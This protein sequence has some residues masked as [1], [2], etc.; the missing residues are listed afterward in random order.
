MQK[1]YGGL[2]AIANI[3]KVLG[4]IDAV[5]A[6]GGAIGIIIWSSLISGEIQVGAYLVTLGGSAIL[7]G[8]VLAL[9]FLFTMG[10]MAVVL[11]AF[12]DLLHLFVAMEE[13]TRATVIMLQSMNK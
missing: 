2:R 1:R 9:I 3:L 11:I 5:V 8:I 10:L 13:N 4:L 7:L 12:G 6:V